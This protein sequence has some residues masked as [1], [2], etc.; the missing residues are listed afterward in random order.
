MITRNRTS[1][2][3][4]IATACLLLAG[5]PAVAQDQE[6]MTPEEAFQQLHEAVVAYERCHN[7]EFDQNQSAALNDRIMEIVDVNL[8]A[9]IKLS[10]IVDAKEEMG[11]RVGAMGCGDDTVAAH[12][13]LF[14][15]QL[16]D[17]LGTAGN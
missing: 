14:D 4:M 7:I 13:E 16:G 8:G 10:L 1:K 12:L 3:P 2:V 6:A 11:S 17:A 9:A 5:S 15:T